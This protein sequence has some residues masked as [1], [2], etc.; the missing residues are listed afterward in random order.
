M[1]KTNKDEFII[2][3][4]MSIICIPIVIIYGIYRMLVNILDNHTLNE[5]NKE[6]VLLYLY[7]NNTGK[8]VD[9]FS[10]M[11]EQIPSINIR[12]VKKLI[13]ILIKEK[14][15][16]IDVDMET[17]ENIYTLDNKNICGE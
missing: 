10:L 13:D 14:R 15:V 9:I 16:F 12:E 11:Q 7:F 3:A 5:N 1:T 8:L 4:V 2:Y 17:G 6:N